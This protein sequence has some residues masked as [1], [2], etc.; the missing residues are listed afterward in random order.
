MLGYLVASAAVAAGLFGAAAFVAPGGNAARDG[1][2]LRGSSVDNLAH[3]PFAAQPA[4]GQSEEV[5][6]FS[7]AFVASSAA[8]VGLMMGVAASPAHAEEDDGSGPQEYRTASK[9]SKRQSSFKPKKE[10]KEEEKKEE[11]GGGF[12]LPSF[13]SFSAPEAKPDA[14]PA[15]KPVEVTP[16]KTKVII[17]PGDEM[18]PDEIPWWKPLFLGKY[19]DLPKFLLFL[20]TPTFIYLTFWVL[21]SLEII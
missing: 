16:E 10:K 11:G 1:A 21:G 7:W 13:P 6:G 18:D 15:A 8:A 5:A 3:R 17:S 4:A 20:C 2:A 12:S 19:F 14:T 9:K